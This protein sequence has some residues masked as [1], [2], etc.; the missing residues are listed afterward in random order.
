MKE[1]SYPEG[2]FEGGYAPA[3]L[4]LTYTALWHIQESAELDLAEA[5]GL[6]HCGEVVLHGLSIRAGRKSLLQGLLNAG[7]LPIE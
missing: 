3:S 6:A 2:I 5:A 7:A 4:P 1:T